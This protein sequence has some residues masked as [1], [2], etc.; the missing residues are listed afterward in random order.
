[1]NIKDIC[2]DRIWYWFTYKGW[3]AIKQDQPN[4]QPSKEVEMA[5]TYTSDRF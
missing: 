3:Y 5:G 2:M 4:K 1:M